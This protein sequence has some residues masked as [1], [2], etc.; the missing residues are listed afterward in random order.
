MNVLPWNR[1]LQTD[2]EHRTLLI[3]DKS[4]TVAYTHRQHP[5]QP[6]SSI[7]SE[8]IWH[9]DWA[10]SH[11]ASQALRAIGLRVLSSRASELEYRNLNVDIRQIEQTGFFPHGA[12]WTMAAVAYRIEQNGRKV[13]LYLMIDEETE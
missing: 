7:S 4:T 3:D 13:A 8:N 9:Y 2:S 5:S 11:Q 6:E 1:C 12:T 10:S